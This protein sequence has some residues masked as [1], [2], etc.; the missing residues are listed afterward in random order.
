MPVRPPAPSARVLRTAPALIDLVGRAAAARRDS[1][2][3]LF[4]LAQAVPDFAPPPHVQ[5]A[6]QACLADPA[7]HRYSVDPGLPELRAAIARV[8]GGLRGADWDPR[9]QVAVTAGANQ[10]FAEVLP[11]LVDAGDE[12]LLLSPYYLNHGMA[13]ELLGAVPVEVP[14]D[15]ERDF[16]VDFAALE[17]AVTARSR[18]LVLVNPSN[19]IGA[20][21]GRPDVERLLD[22]AA[23]HGLWVVSDETYEDYVLDPPTG[24]WTSA[25]AVAG[26]GDRVIVLGSFSKSA[27]LSGWRVGWIAG[28]PALMREVLKAHDTMII[29]APVAGQRGALASLEGDR[30]WLAPRRGEIAARR[31]FVLDFLASSRRLEGALGASRGAMFVLVRPR[32][33][34]LADSTRAA[35]D[36]VASSGVA[37]VPGVAFG[38]CGEGWLRLSFAGAGP[39]VLAEALPALEEA[40]ASA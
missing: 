12:V 7:T 6:L 39:D 40:L 8:L 25:A 27:G 18:A 9:T 19:P 26:H 31:R 24:G 21:L 2:G 29:C 17:R 11:A 36:V 28:P 4:P 3:R 13:A 23:A 35:L 32:G 10:A 33:R 30:A 37:L 5:E 16:A 20:V 34:V 15:A 1:G 22:F 14:L 38:R